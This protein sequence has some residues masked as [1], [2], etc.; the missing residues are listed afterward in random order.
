LNLSTLKHVKEYTTQ[1][2]TV[3]EQKELVAI[4]MA[5]KQKLKNPT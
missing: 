3:L 2:V 4:K 5:E 1:T